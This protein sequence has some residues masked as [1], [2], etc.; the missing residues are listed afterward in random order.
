M[1]QRYNESTADLKELMT[2]APIAPEL[3]AA[4]VRKQVAMRRLME[5]IREEARLLGDELLG[6]EQKSA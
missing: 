6:A 4:L 3:H 1:H 5:D 2:A